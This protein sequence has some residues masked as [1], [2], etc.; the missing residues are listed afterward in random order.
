MRSTTYLDHDLFAIIPQFRAG[1]LPDGRKIAHGAVLGAHIV[2]NSKVEILCEFIFVHKVRH[3]KVG[4][5]V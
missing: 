1:L 3:L 5:L 2:V 4:S